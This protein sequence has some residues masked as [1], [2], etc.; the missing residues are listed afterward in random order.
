M[1]ILPVV[2]LGV[3][4]GIIVALI[5][6]NWIWILVCW[7]GSVVVG[8]IGLFIINA[9]FDHRKAAESRQG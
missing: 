7:L 4:I 2:I 1:A 8:I 5:T 3:V 9:F 6:G